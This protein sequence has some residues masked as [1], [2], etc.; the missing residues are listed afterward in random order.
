VRR[1]LNA[2]EPLLDRFPLVKSLFKG[3]NDIWPDSQDRVP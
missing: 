1:P 2:L 3:L